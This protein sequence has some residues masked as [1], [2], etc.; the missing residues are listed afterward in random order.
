LNRAIEEGEKFA[1]SLTLRDAE[2][3]AQTLK[4]SPPW[5]Y[6]SEAQISHPLI[7][8]AIIQICEIQPADAVAELHA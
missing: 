8:K 2:G 6:S 5:F 4:Q 3:F 7:F 1:Q